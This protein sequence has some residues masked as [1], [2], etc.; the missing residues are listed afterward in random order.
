MGNRSPGAAQQPRPA[1]TSAPLPTCSCTTLS[2]H[3]VI[4]LRLLLGR[5][6]EGPGLRSRPLLLLLAVDAEGKGTCSSQLLGESQ[7]P[8]NSAPGRPMAKQKGRMKPRREEP[9]STAARVFIQPATAGTHGAGQVAQEKVREEAPH[10]PAS[11]KGDAHERQRTRLDSGGSE[12]SPSAPS[13]DPA[14]T[15]GSSHLPHLQ[16]DR[17][18][19][20]SMGD[21]MESPGA[22][23]G[24]SD[25]TERIC[26]QQGPRPP[27]T[28]GCFR[29][30]LG[31]WGQGQVGRRGH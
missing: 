15:P 14:A 12:S 25:C 19:T 5:T 4:F 31:M 17:S 26:G 10:A 24:K 20:G 3:C 6:G 2:Q 30:S 16:E 8:G 1:P 13:T 28:K 29:W 21:G 27:L 22:A 18:E 11:G 7:H 23:E 9:D